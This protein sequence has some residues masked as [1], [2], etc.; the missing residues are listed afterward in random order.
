MKEEMKEKIKNLVIQ[1]AYENHLHPLDALKTTEVLE[2][3]GGI[4]SSIYKSLK[5]RLETIYPA[6]TQPAVTQPAVTKPAVTK[7]AVTPVQTTE[8]T[9]PAHY[10]SNEQLLAWYKSLRNM[11]EST[12][13]QYS[14]MYLKPV[15]PQPVEPQPVEATETF[16]Q[17]KDMENTELER[18]ERLSNIGKELE[19]E[20][21]ILSEEK[22]DTFELVFGNYNDSWTDDRLAEADA[23]WNKLIYQ[24]Q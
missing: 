14:P 3:I 23:N 9:R 5:T 20:Y 6:V 15:E 7:P 21:S 24:N 8:N 4:D 1:H 19:I 2:I 18:D 16:T 12:Q 13:P 10:L 17:R 22:K 11:P